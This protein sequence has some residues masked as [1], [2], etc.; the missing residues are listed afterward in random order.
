MISLPLNVLSVFHVVDSHGYPLAS[1]LR[2]IPYLWIA[3]E[4][5]WTTVSQRPPPTNAGDSLSSL[6]PRHQTIDPHLDLCGLLALKLELAGHVR[7]T[8]DTQLLVL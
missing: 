6:R 7:C 5:R 2:R 3:L 4:Y 1:D 8:P